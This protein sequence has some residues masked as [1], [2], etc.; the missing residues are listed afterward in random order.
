MGMPKSEYSDKFDEG[1]RA[2]VELSY[3]KYG[4][5]R[6]N[7]TR[8][9]VDA[10]ASHDKCIEAYRETGNTEYLMDAANYLMFEFMYPTV[11]GAHFK[12]TD[13]DGSAGI[14][15]MSIKEMEDF[16]NGD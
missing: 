6:V 11:E 12:P 16:K 4:S 14:V 2:R 5:A 3:Y 13:S 7:F 15:G 8:R 9:L 10:L 1:R